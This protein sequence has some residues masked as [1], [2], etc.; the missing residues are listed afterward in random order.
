MLVDEMEH[1]LQNVGMDID[2]YLTSA[3]SPDAKTFAG[4][5]G[6]SVDQLRQWRHR[7]DNRRPGPELCVVIEKVSDG[8]I[9]RWDLR[10]DDWHRI[11]PELINAE[12]APAIP[13]E[14]A[15]G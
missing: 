5:I 9:R 7:Y 10:P 3:G 2:S 13:Q 14:V 4:V 12:G 6:V 11:W 8:V 1:L 15:H